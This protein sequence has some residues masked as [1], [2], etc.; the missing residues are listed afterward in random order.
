MVMIPEEHY[1]E[2]KTVK[3]TGEQIQHIIEQLRFATHDMFEL[4]NFQK[5]IDKLRI[6]DVSSTLNEKKEKQCK[7][8]QDDFIPN[9]DENY[10]A[11]CDECDPEDT[12]TV[13]E[14][15]K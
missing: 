9:K 12:K 6:T 3:L 14:K 10:C 13:K 7:D 1:T 8:C 15:G 2:E 4:G 5:I 11:Y